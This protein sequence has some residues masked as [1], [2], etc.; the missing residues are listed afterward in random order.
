MATKATIADLFPDHEGT[1]LVAKDVSDGLPRRITEVPNGGDCGCICFGCGR[2]MIARNGGDPDLRAYSFAHHPEDNVVDC[3]SS[4]ETA[5]HIRAKEIIAKHCRVTLPATSTPGLDGKPVDVSPQRSVDLT[6]IHPELVVGEV[7]PDIVATMPDD[8]RIF[9]EIANTHLCSPEKIEKLDAMGV[10]VLEIVVSQY[11]SHPLDEL[12]DIILDTAPRKLIHS[13]EVKAMAAKIAEERQ[14]Q[15]DA[16]IAEAKRLVAIYRDPDIWNHKKAQKLVD[17]LVQLG[18]SEFLDLDDDRPSAFIVYRRQ[19]Q[20]AIFD[21]FSKAKFALGAMAFVE[22]FSKGGWPKPGI[23]YTKSEHSR[24][25]AANVDEDF[26]SPYEEVFAYLR[27]LRRAGAVYEVPVKQ[28]VLGHDIQVR[29]DTAIQKRARPERQ[30]KELRIAFD[31][32]GSLMLPEDGRLPDYDV[33]LNSRAEYFNLS[34]DELFAD[35]DGDYEEL[36]DQ[37]IAVRTMVEDMQRLK[38]IDPPDEMAGLPMDRL[39]NRLGLARLDA[40]QRLEAEMAARRQRQAIETAARLQQEAADRVYKAKE[41]ALFTVEDIDVFME[42]A[43]PEHG[44]KTPRELAAESSDGLK[45][46]Q[47]IL[48]RIR[49]DKAAA[50]RAERIRNALVDKLHDRVYRVILRRDVADLWLTAQCKELGWI[51]PV[52]YC[53]DEKTLARCLEVLEEFAA[54][55]RKRGRR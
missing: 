37:V 13:S 16:K 23:A 45:R 11:R 18:L 25:I 34:V 40:E 21:R 52:D 10:E 33:W 29:I 27:R 4:G 35:E 50:E 30:R 20:A 12:D 47:A 53:K 5:L 31:G 48:S 1:I 8:R 32:V 54:I 38:H 24:W 42:A 55:E 7:I 14:Q 2:R 41:A 36:L 9:I 44:G 49:D 26:K 17:D 51:K 43:L 15:E 22:S 39:I 3:V 28:F 46:V 6:D 19:W